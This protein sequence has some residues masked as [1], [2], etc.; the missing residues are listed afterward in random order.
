MIMMR[1]AGVVIVA[2][3]LS[4]CA[5][6]HSVTPSGNI[7]AGTYR[8]AALVPQEG[9]SPEVDGYVRDALA[10]QEITLLPPKPAGTKTA[11][12][13]DLLASYLD[14]WRWDLHTYLQSIRIDL[15]DARSGALLVSGTWK[16]S[17]F[18]GFQRGKDEAKKLLDEMILRI[19]GKAK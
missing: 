16:D 10:A 13:V 18:H 4:G 5:A 2:M 14:V 1:W 12:D 15:F 9:N 8:T 6:S 19:R 11:E 3:F 7:T 17:Y